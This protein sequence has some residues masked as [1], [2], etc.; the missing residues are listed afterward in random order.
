[1][2]N[3][4]RRVLRHA[5]IWILV[6]AAYLVA[7]K[8]GLALAFVNASATA[9]WPPTGIALAVVL[10]YGNRIWPAIFLGAFL[11]NQLTAGTWLTSLMIA[12][13]N[14]LEALL[15]AYLVKR[16]VPEPGTFNRG[17]DLVV[18]L[19][20]AALLSTT[21]SATIGV[22]T[23]A[24][25]GFAPWSAY[26]LI[27]FTWW[28]GDATAAAVIAPAILLWTTN[29]RIEWSRRQWAELWLVL[30]TLVGVGW[31]VF[32]RSEYPLEFLCIPICVWVAFRFGEREAATA[33]CVVSAVA[34]W[35]SIR[36]LG[37]FA[38]QS[39]QDVL[40]LLQA[41][42]AVVSIVGI[43]VGTAVSGRRLAERL[44]R[45]ANAELESQVRARTRELASSEGRLAEAQE[46]A[47]VGS[48]EWNIADRRQSWSEELYRI[49]GVDQSFRPTLD[50]FL[51]AIPPDDRETVTAITRKALRD[52]QPFEFEHRFIRPDG[53]VRMLHSH[54]RVVTDE[55]GQVI[56]MVGTA[57]D[58]TERHRLEEH[59]HHAQKME[60]IGRLAGG[61]AH[62]F[63]NLLTAIGCYTEMMLEQIGNDKPISADL[64]EIRKAAESAAGLTRQ[65]LIVSRKEVPRAVPLD[66]NVVITNVARLLRRTLGEDIVLS[67]NLAED[68]E[69]IHADMMQLQQVILNLAVNGRDSMP[70][71]G[72]LAI[73]TANVELANAR[74][75]THAGVAPG[76]YVQLTVGDTGQGMDAA[77]KARMFE[78]FF[79][80][81]EL[82]HGTG[83]GLATAYAIIEQCGGTIWVESDVGRGTT[84]KLCFP[85]YELRAEKVPPEVVG[86]NENLLGTETVLIVED[87]ENVRTL[88]SRTLKRHGYSVHEAAS[89]TRAVVLVQEIGGPIDILLTDVVMPGMSGW[90]LGKWFGLHSSETR[91]LYMS[92]HASRMRVPSGMTVDSREFL[93]KPFT[94]AALLRNIRDR[95]DWNAVA[96]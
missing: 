73:Q 88:A 38:G 94:V 37:T 13:G 12:G 63:N 40:L 82:G 23:L 15:G 84:F 28:L 2:S 1:M 92:G 61:I 62:D 85:A 36:G 56:R 46:V 7:G 79:T 25:F 52:R 39:T 60:A 68:V 74:G 17:R 51:A 87:D 3:W 58:I 6:A 18:F 24:L 75:S 86:S 16:F 48:W 59:L 78:P 70:N 53:E 47:H 29:P 44:L 32:I 42:M 90:D 83:L 49:C 33:T 26:R 30:A 71:G 11:T 57:Q 64:H 81:K 93:Q 76:R 67:T 50:A 35:G 95:L 65:L 14:T 31:F 10:L 22:T 27:W 21:V 5:A 34:V 77:T 43:T 66:L 9:V 91:I 45:E 4:R 96:D 72:T 41:F 8:A 20:L 55:S 69:A 19:V 89:A 54:G 80:T